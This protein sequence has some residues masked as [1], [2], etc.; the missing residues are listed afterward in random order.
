VIAIAR[1]V[2]AAGEDVAR[3]AA[4]RVGFRLIDYQVIQEAAREAGVSPETV[5]EAEHTPSLLTRILESL[6]RNPSMP[7][8]AWADPLPLSTNPLFTSADFR[9]FVEQVIRNIAEQGDC[10]IVGHAAQVILRSRPDT[11]RVLIT[12]SPQ[13][14][15]PRIMAG[16]SVD[17][18]TALKT[19]ERTDNE[20][21]DYFRRFYD[22]GWLTPCVY[23]LCINTDEITPED[24]AEL[25]VLA[26]RLR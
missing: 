16:M 23:D 5:S 10:V 14:R 21:L 19:V 26:A 4:V 1:Q 9:K 2:G 13:H 25:V 20:R 7:V 24:A 6:A 22:T 8:A 17:E 12:G 15:A 3:A 11:L 18:K